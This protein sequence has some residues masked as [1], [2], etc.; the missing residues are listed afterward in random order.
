MPPEEK[1]QFDHASVAS[2]SASYE[3]PSRASSP[4]PSSPYTKKLPP[5]SVV[6]EAS[7][8]EDPA[9]IRR[10]RSN[11]VHAQDDRRDRST[12]RVDSLDDPKPLPSCP[13]EVPSGSYDDW[14]TLRGYKGFNICPSCYN[15]VFAGTRYEVDFKQIWRDDW[16]T[17]KACDF[18]NPWTRLAW[19][20]TVKQRRKSLDLIYKVAEIAETYRS[21]PGDREYDTDR[22]SWYGIPDQ[23]DG[24]HVKNFAVCSMDRRLIEA[25]LPTLHGYFTLITPG[26]SSIPE[27]YTCSLRAKSRRFPKYMDLLV[28]LDAEA[29]SLGTRPDIIRFIR[30]ARDNAFKSEC[31]RDKLL[32]RKAWHFIPSLP[33]FTVC[34]ECYDELI[35]PA[36]QSRSMTSTIPHLFSKVVQLVPDED[37]EFGSSCC[38]YSP[39]MRKVWKEAIADDDFAYLKEQ[40]LRRKRMEIRLARERR[41][42]DM[43]MGLAGKG[44]SRYEWAMREKKVLEREWATWE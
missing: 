36:M 13:R 40:A 4:V 1:Y 18:S 8:S 25:L 41:D 16:A 33:E 32:M 27:T 31:C 12:R 42:I 34:Q 26:Y 14:Y 5:R 23:R 20:L 17:E 30:L 29:Q 44:D 35:W 22:R 9:R 38:L 15:G 7:S 37:A 6:Q 39:R 11:S 19:M 28:E 10:T 21:C 43:G 24:V 3:Y 2:P